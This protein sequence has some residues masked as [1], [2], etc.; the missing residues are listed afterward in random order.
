MAQQVRPEVLVARRTSSDQ[1][2]EPSRQP[3]SGHQPFTWEGD[4]TL[5]SYVLSH[6]CRP[7]ETR[8]LIKTFWRSA[9]TAT[10]TCVCVSLDRL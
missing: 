5:H 4:T 1:T 9:D 6:R 3:L 2:D 8:G 10:T 7:F